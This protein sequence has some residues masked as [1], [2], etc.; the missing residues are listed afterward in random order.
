[1][2]LGLEGIRT[3]SAGSAAEVENIIGDPQPGDVLVTDYRLDGGQ[4]GLDIL[5]R[6]RSM[7]GRCLPAVLLSGDLESMMRAI[8]TPVPSCR[9]LSKPVDTQALLQAIVDLSAA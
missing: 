6:I 8:K 4:T 7:Q 9:F 2:Y 3:V 1:M 5:N